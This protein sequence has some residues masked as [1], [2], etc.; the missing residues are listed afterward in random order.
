MLVRVTMYSPCDNR[1]AAALHGPRDLPIVVWANGIRNCFQNSRVLSAVGEQIHNYQRAV[2]PVFGK[3]DASPNRRV[4]LSLICG[5]R[6][7]HYKADARTITVPHS[8]E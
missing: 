8:G 1:Q 4:I 2:S 7:E 6:I 5:A 3:P